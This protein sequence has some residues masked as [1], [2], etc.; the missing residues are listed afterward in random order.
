MKLIG[1]SITLFLA[2]ATSEAALRSGSNYRNL[3]GAC[4]FEEVHERINVVGQFSDERAVQQ[5]CN[6]DPFCHGYALFGNNLFFTLDSIGP[7]DNFLNQCNS[8]SYVQVK[9]KRVETP[10]TRGNNEMCL[11]LN[12]YDAVASCR[13][14]ERDCQLAS[15]E[16]R[17]DCCVCGGGDVVIIDETF[18]DEV[19]LPFQT[20][21]ALTYNIKETKV[22]VLKGNPE[23]FN[24]NIPTEIYSLTKL[25][26]LDLSSNDFVGTIP[27]G[28]EQ[29]TDLE[30]L[31]ITGNSLQGPLPEGLASLKKLTM[32]N[33]EFNA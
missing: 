28:I 4:D 14:S 3:G 13:L 29:L 24:G 19:T 30:E 31:I 1:I 12:R 8:N 21:Q 2:L 16:T 33:I 18:T 27:D 25:T 10:H 20:N 9:E 7:L 11:D 5:A 26:S 32:V 22:L 15:E 6:D 23:Q 17:N